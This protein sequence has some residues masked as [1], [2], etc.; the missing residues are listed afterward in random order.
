MSNRREFLQSAIA[1]AATTALAGT[2]HFSMQV[3]GPQPPKG[4]LLYEIAGQSLFPIYGLS[5]GICASMVAYLIK[6]PYAKKTD[7]IG[8]GFTDMEFQAVSHDE[9]AIRKLVEYKFRKAIEEGQISK[10][11]MDGG[12]LPYPQFFNA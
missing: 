11:S 4:W 5:G 8:V 2:Y 10:V 12:N 9:K 7:V 1:A 6:N 3:F